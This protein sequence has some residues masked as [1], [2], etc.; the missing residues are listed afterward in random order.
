LVGSG[1]YLAAATWLEL[2]LATERGKVQYAG[3]GSNW[4]ILGGLK[5]WLELKSARVELAK[6]A[7]TGS[8]D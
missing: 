6:S 4:T 5:A 2:V 7:K 8:P 3:S 1:E